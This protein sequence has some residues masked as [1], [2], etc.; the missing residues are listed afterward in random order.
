MFCKWCGMES[1]TTD[2]CSWCRRA[3][4]S[5]TAAPG[6]TVT[7]PTD[8]TS[9]AAGKQAS[10]AA[11][12]TT[13][14]A[15]PLAPD[16]T[17]VED[18]PSATEPP[19]PPATMPS[20]RLPWTPPAEE[21]APSAPAAPTTPPASTPPAV[22]TERGER[23]TIG[24]RRPGEKRPA[25][26][27]PPPSSGQR[28]PLTMPPPAATRPT[29]TPPPQP[30]SPPH[31]H[32]P[33]PPM[34]PNLPRTAPKVPL[35]GPSETA[36]Q[37]PPQTS[38]APIAPIVP[39][40]EG[41]SATAPPPVPTP[42]S[43]PT[44]P[45]TL[46]G[47]TTP[48]I[49]MTAPTAPGGSGSLSGST[50]LAEAVRPEAPAPS[51]PPSVQAAHEL[52]VPAFGTFTPEKSKYYSGQLID[53]VSGTHYDSET[54]LPMKALERTNGNAAHKTQDV[55]LHW[56]DS[57]TVE[58]SRVSQF[59]IVF[60]GIL[61]LA[62]IAAYA[63]SERYV[64]PLLLAQFFGAL[65]MPIMKV[66][67][68]AD[69]DSDDVWVFLLLTLAGG[70]LVALVVYGVI[71]LL[72]QNANPGIVG[73]LA[74]A[75]LARLTVDIAAGGFSLA[76]LNPFAQV[77]HFEPRLLLINWSGLTALAGWYAASVFHKLD[78]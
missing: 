27:M 30:V 9:E 18:L 23:P 77:G 61:S 64:L 52:H 49:S 34:P 69:E 75:L 76:G 73:C 40:N 4:A 57:P 45:Q 67:P 60:A 72:R 53:P 3:F 74:I 39:K 41:G 58:A 65:L 16:S 62:G 55:V 10:E 38:A 5:S 7:G 35:A 48:T 11:A 51:L 32:T 42:H 15:R 22:G 33:A 17:L 20:V 14:T 12:L 24:V 71:S 25:P 63:F 47:T 44:V 19:A 13:P 26:S 37:S 50:A 21:A 43:R 36:P 56:D 68:W 1:T 70:P 59:A 8:T 46:L 29:A 78:E 28:P 54:G 66:A 6:S 31:A 2:K